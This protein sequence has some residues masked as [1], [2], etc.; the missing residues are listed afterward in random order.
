[1]IITSLIRKGKSELY[2]T[3]LN[4]EYVCLLEAETIVKHKLKTGQEIDQDEFA[5]IREE[6]ENLTCRKQVLDYV[7][8]GIKTRKQVFD[9]FKQKGYLLISI[10]NALDMLEGYGYLNDK[11]YAQNFVKAKQNQKG[12]MY[13]VSSLKQKG[14]SDDI[15]NEVLQD[16]A[17]EQDVVIELAQKYL[18]NKVIDDK[19][20]EKLFRHLISKGF[21]FSEVNSAIKS[22]LKNDNNNY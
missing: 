15:I 14:V 1:M 21:D 4:E 7:S 5:R 19:T 16:F 6:S 17:T 22:V 20:K 10:N 11:Y 13:I 12:K 2:K 18:K 9:H 3:Y 8:K